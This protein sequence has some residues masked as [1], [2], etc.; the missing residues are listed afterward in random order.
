MQRPVVWWAGAVC[1]CSALASACG[2]SSSLGS[3]LTPSG[4][5]VSSL[6]IFVNP[7]SVGGGAQAT[8]T[9]TFSNG[10]TS[11]VASGFGTDTP[12]VATAATGGAI[13]G[14]SVGDVTIFVDYQGMRASKKVRVLPS[15]AGAYL[16]TYTI[17]SCVATGGF[18]STDP[19]A[20]FCTEFTTGRV[21]QMALQNTQS[22]DLTTVTGL[23]RLGSLQGS[24]NGTI[25]SVGALA[26]AGAVVGSTTRMD[27]R[28]FS[29]TSP[30][31]GRIAGSFDQVWT[32]SANTGSA[33]VTCT[34]MDMTRQ[35]SA[36]ATAAAPLAVRAWDPVSVASRI[37]RD[38]RM[39][40]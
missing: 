2:S 3:Q 5:T 7:P 36:L 12:S 27:F 28:N 23:F 31:P 26:Y 40:Q 30:A 1:V 15:Y 17:G 35:S 29:A 13:T 20:N 8:A 22:A 19:A 4:V 6:A 32:D 25:S 34:N 39:I 11:P 21:L 14:V 18:V 10:S 9:A 24:G 16:G 38:V 37:L 33:I